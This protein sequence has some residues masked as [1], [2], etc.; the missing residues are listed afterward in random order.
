MTLLC[1]LQEFRDRTN[2][3]EGTLGRGQGTEGLVN[4]LFSVTSTSF[5]MCSYRNYNSKQKVQKR[6]HM[7]SNRNNN[8]NNNL[9]S[10]TNLTI[11]H[12]PLKPLKIF[13]LDLCNFFRQ[14]LQITFPF[15]QVDPDLSGHGLTCRETNKL[16]IPFR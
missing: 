4:S 11:Y 14:S 7:R 13:S 5:L 10:L 3:S 8:T 1:C 16:K 15:C 9:L 6:F 12:P 2:I